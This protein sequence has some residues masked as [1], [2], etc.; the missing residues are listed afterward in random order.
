MGDPWM[1]LGRLSGGPHILKVFVLCSTAA[2]RSSDEILKRDFWRVAGGLLSTSRFLN[3]FAW[4]FCCS[5]FGFAF[6]SCRQLCRRNPSRFVSFPNRSDYVR[7]L[8]AQC[9]ARAVAANGN[10]G[11]T[12]T[13][14]RTHTHTHAP[15]RIFPTSRCRAARGAGQRGA[16]TAAAA[17]RRAACLLW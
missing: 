16:A 5:S 6:G 15:T 2:E 10:F 8:R 13:V 11:V 1:V 12:G 14:P 17:G 4:R 9:F 7:H 3:V